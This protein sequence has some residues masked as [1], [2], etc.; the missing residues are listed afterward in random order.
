[1]VA[2]E[3]RR[4]FTALFF[5]DFGWKKAERR[6]VASAALRSSRPAERIDLHHAYVRSL[7]YGLSRFPALVGE[8]MAVLDAEAVA[9]V[10]DADG[11]DAAEAE[12]S[13]VRAQ[14]AELLEEAFR[15]GQ[16]VEQ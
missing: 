6:A 9:A 11:Y 3:Y 15:L 13:G 2:D 5:E 12:R 7:L 8:H 1:M 14:Q 10:A 16:P 4:G